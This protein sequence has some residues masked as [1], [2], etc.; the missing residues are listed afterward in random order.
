[1]VGEGRGAL[2]EGNI[3]NFEIWESNLLGTC[4]HLLIH[5]AIYSRYCN[6]H[7]KQYRPIMFKATLTPLLLCAAL[8][9][10]GCSSSNSGNTGRNVG[11]AAGAILGAVVGSQLGDGSGVNMAAGAAAGAALGGLGGS[12]YDQNKEEQAAAEAQRQYEYDQEAQ[13]QVKLEEEIQTL[14]AKRV[15]DEI[16]RNSTTSDVSAAEREAARLEA[17][18][19]AKKKA[20]AESQERAKRIQEAQARA[21]KAQAE[22]AE[23]E[24]QENGG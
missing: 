23:M 5:P 7:T 18:L 24:R 13:A 16:A 21:A 6:F 22:L 2:P 14:E 9:F 8:L 15:R 1:M 12:K 19:A 3:N 4:L 17:E 20:Y 10:S 11:V